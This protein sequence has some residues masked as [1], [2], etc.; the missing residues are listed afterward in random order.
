MNQ[1]AYSH[2]KGALSQKRQGSHT[3]RFNM[4]NLTLTEC[5]AELR[6]TPTTVL[7]PMEPL[8]SMYDVP[9]FYRG[10]LVAVCGKAKSGKTLFLS[11]IMAA[12]LTQ[13]VL[14]LERHTDFTDLTDGCS[15]SL[16]SKSEENLEENLSKD[17]TD[18]KPL[19]VL[20]ID[21][22]QSQQSTQDIMVNRIMPLVRGH[23]EGVISH[24][25]PTDRTDNNFRVGDFD[26]CF[27]A[28][29]LRGLGFERR[30]ELMEAA[31]VQVKPDLVVI[32]GIKDLV[33]DIN[34]AIQATIIMEQLMA[35]AQA[36]HCCIVNVLHQNKSEA[37]HNMR[38]SIGT[39]LSNKAFEVYTCE[40]IERYDTF[41]VSQRL[42][43][44]DRIKRR[45]YYKLDDDHIPVEC[46]EVP[47]QARDILGRYTSLSD[48][49]TE[50]TATDAKDLAKLFTSAMEG[51]QQRPYSELMAVALKHFGVKDAQTYYAYVKEAEEQG[52]IRKVEHPDTKVTWVELVDNEI[53][54]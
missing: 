1:E 50:D 44:R 33:T 14:A 8:F 9:C 20:W 37:D 53:P 48:T 19:R 35:L 4:D 36:H 23:T 22:E 7:P 41:K 30:R 46:E 34:D 45:L 21:T 26:D 17:S 38:G 2:I 39:E 5:L 32:D 15:G 13:K 25:D 29:N 10:E 40:F 3:E 28:Y 31:I 12:C 42:S 27:F 6:V 52:I 54:F 18:I 49:E 11:V 47:E 16:R 43:R 51:R 24:T